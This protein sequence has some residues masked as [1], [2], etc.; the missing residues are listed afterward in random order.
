MFEHRLP[1]MLTPAQSSATSVFEVVIA[2]F[3]PSMSTKDAS[4]SL[5]VL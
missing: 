1:P 4:S 5:A 3:L 2:L